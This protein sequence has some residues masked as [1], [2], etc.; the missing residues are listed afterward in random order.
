MIAGD[1]FQTLAGT[2]VAGTMRWLF[3]FPALATW[4]RPTALQTAIS[5]RALDPTQM[6]VGHGAVLARPGEQM[7]AAIRVAEVQLDGN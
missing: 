4:H 5:L 3:P 6:A 1:A 7:D 2:A